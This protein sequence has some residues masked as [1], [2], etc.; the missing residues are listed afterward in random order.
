[1]S[2]TFSKEQPVQSKKPEIGQ[3][4]ETLLASQEFQCYQEI[5]DKKRREALFNVLSVDS[6]S[7]IYRARL[8]V[9]DEVI[10]IPEHEIKKAEIYKQ[11]E[12]EDGERIY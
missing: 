4:M 5:L 9:L 8:K 7:K 3:M 11:G 6:D 1:M 10:G 12:N 2:L